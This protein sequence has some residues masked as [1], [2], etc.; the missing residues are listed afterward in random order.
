[1]GRFLR[2]IVGDHRDRARALRV[3]AG[4]PKRGARGSAS[5]GIVAIVLARSLGVLAFLG[6]AR[7]G[8]HDTRKHPALV[9][10]LVDI[11]YYV[12]WC[13]CLFTIVPAVVALLVASARRPR[14]AALPAEVPSAFFMWTYARGARRVRL[15]HPHSS[16]MVS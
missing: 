11:P 4:S 15:R 6:R 7:S 8:M 10:W 13:A 16:P 5:R 1:M 2:I 9:V 3:R 14:S 12:H